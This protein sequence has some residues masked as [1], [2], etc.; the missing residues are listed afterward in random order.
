M[1]EKRIKHFEELCIHKKHLIDSCHKMSVHFLKEGNEEFALLLMKRAFVHDISKLSEYEFHA[2]DALDSFNK[3]SRNREYVFSDKEKVFL[4]EHWKNNRHHPE[5]WDDINDM[6]D[7][8]LAEMVCDWHARSTEFND[9]LLAYI[10][11]RQ[12]TRYAF[13]DNLYKKILEYANILLSSQ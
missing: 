9:D 6:N 10:K 2:S 5:H 1:N 13:P 3:H 11:H 12:S 7:I 8:D 4:E